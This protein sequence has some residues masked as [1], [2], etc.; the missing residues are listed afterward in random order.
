M[1]EIG[2][3]IVIIFLLVL[4][5]GVLAMTEIAVVSARKGRLRSLSAKGEKRAQSAL[6]LAESPN[7]FL[8]TVQIGI[9][10]VGILAGAYGGATIA[11]K[12][13]EALAG[14]PVLGPHAGSISV[15][16][17]VAGIT[18]FSLVLGELV[19]KRFGLAKPE[20]IAMVMAKPMHGISLVAKPLVKFLEVSTDCL[21][22]IFGFRAEDG[23][24]VSE[25]EV[26][27]LMQEGLRAGAFNKVES[28]IV[29][30]ALELDKVLVRDIMTPRPKIIWISW[31]EEHE[32][33]WH[34]VV[35]SGHTSFPVYEG[36]RDHV[37]GIVSLKAIYANVAAGSP[38]K[39]RDLMTKPLV[40]PST[41]DAI[42]LLE[43]F[44][45]EGKYLALVADEFGVIVGLVTL[46]DVMEAL[47][48]ELPSAEERAKPGA[49]RRE[50]GSWLIDGMME[51]AR[52]VAILPNFKLSS[53]ENEDYKTLAGYVVRELGHMPKEGETVR[54]QGYVFEVLDM[55]G[56]RVDKVLVTASPTSVERKA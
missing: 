30:S 20:G 26:K 12:L 32:T 2:F 15:G 22:R 51:I 27:V 38:P 42:Q 44:K 23:Q 17:V 37:V 54:A 21:L 7:R 25:E 45:R 39:F 9:T 50:D 49:R 5:N 14:V 46:H 1:K 8:A 10:L 48:G 41:Q 28:E 40:V 18:Y 56:H 52:V 55:D 16:I 36:N 4:T 13:R 47:V 6:Q 53:E 24:T 43:T 35:V 34:K 11:E 31:D 29:G 19:P 33:V 3:E